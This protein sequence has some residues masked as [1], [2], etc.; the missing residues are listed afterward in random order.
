MSLHRV[1]W[2]RR[3]ALPLMS[4]FNAGDITIRHHHTGQPLRLHS[5]KH[6]GYW[7]HGRNRERAT[8]ELFARLLRPGDR[9]FEVGGHIGYIAMFFSHWV[10]PR[11]SVHVFEPGENNLPYLLHNTRELRNLTV[12][13][14]AAGASDGT[15]RFFLEDLTGQ[16]NTLVSNYDVFSENRARAHV[17]AGYRT[18]EV[19]VVRLDSFVAGS[20][21]RPD[22]VKID[23]EGAEVEV[24]RGMPTTLQKDRPGIMVEVTRSAEQVAQ[25]L[26]D[27]GYVLFDDALKERSTPA[28]LRGNIFALHGVRH[29]DVLSGL[30]LRPA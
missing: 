10:G 25:I 30:G 12:V 8:M 7:F 5:F 6:K 28:E 11:G 29:Q 2:L 1:K 3:F 4:R 18:T 13:E 14:K 15:A 9:V 20:G 22:F 21:C 26:T 17:D 16:N 27:A 24:L 19:E 23:V